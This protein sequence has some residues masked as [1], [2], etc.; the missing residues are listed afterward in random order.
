VLEYLKKIDPSKWMGLQIYTDSQ[1][2]INMIMAYM[3]KWTDGKFN[4][5][6]NPDLTKKM[7]RLWNEYPEHRLDII[8]VPA[9]NKTNWKDSPNPYKRWCHDNNF[10][11]DKLAKEVRLD[12]S[13]GT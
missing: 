8:F 11:A 9:H 7:W 1:F 6:K 10:E 5:Q 4:S 3:P 13:L 12:A 2:W